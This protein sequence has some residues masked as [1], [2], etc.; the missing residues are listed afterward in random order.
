MSQNRDI[1]RVCGNT[2]RVVDHFMGEGIEATLVAITGDQLESEP[3]TGCHRRS[4][5]RAAENQRSEA[6]AW[7]PVSRYGANRFGLITWNGRRRVT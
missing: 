6:G 4:C 2:H 1:D 5:R 3:G 7:A